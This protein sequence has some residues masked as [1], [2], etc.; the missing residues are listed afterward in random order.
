[1]IV[2]LLFLLGVLLVAVE[3]TEAPSSAPGRAPRPPRL[4]DAT[5]FVIAYPL[6][7]FDHAEPGVAAH[8]AGLGQSP[9]N[10]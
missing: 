5:A 4:R 2:L 10:T 3:L 6:L 9:R 8:G 7:V 1:M